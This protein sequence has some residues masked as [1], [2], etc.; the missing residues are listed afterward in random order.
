MKE[1]NP[2]VAFAVAK[3]EKADLQVNIPATSTGRSEPL[4]VTRL[5]PFEEVKHIVESGRAPRRPNRTRPMSDDE[6]RKAIAS[7]L[8]SDAELSLTA[9]EI[10]PTE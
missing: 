9:T 8:P 6:R 2:M 7:R 10:E 4:A 1:G 3:N 5:A